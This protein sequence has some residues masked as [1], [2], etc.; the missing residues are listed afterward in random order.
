MLGRLI[1]ILL[2]I[3]VAWSVGPLLYGHVPVSGKF[4]LFVYAIIFAIVVFVTGVLAALVVKDVSTPS[5]AS[6]TA[7]VVVALIAAAVATY[8]PIYFPEYYPGTTL[9]Q[10]GLVL[11]GAILGYMIRR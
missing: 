10:R 8:G 6:L 9:S 5:S 4:G 2:Q 3:A 7:A 11:A 1:L